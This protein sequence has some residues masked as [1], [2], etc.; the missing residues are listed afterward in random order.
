MF[1]VE[2]MLLHS[3]NEDEVRYMFKS[4]RGLASSAGLSPI[5]FP[6]SLLS[7]PGKKKALVSP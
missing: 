6:T 1:I 3:L 4:K 2:H 7:S 5:P